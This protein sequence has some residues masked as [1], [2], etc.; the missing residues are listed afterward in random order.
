MRIC[1]LKGN[2][3]WKNKLKTSKVTKTQ[4]QVRIPDKWLQRFG[5]ARW[6]SWEGHLHIPLTRP[7]EGAFGSHS[8]HHHIL[9]LFFLV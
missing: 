6:I 7:G 4:P 5:I 1:V 8:A 3:M 2:M 9:G